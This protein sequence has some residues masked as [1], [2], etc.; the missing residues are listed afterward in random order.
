MVSKIFVWGIVLSMFL[1][2]GAGCA[3]TFDAPLRPAPGLFFTSYTIPLTTEFDG[4]Q[5]SGL[6]KTE[7][8]TAYLFWPY[9]SFDVAWDNGRDR[10]FQAS[11]QSSIQYADLEVFT[12]FGIFGRYRV[13][14]Y[15][16]RNSAL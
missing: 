15:G 3:N 4:Q 7:T 13:N 10:Y 8:E 5:V 11:R 9:P 12:V 14:Y 1:M 2:L 6:I 16:P